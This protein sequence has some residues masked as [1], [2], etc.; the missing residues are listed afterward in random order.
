MSLV[1]LVIITIYFVNHMLLQA[2]WYG[3]VDLEE[4]DEEGNLTY[5]DEYFTV[6]C[7]YY[8][9]MRNPVYCNNISKTEVYAENKKVECV[10][11][12]TGIIGKNLP[13]TT[14]TGGITP[15]CS[16][17]LKPFLTYTLMW[18]LQPQQKP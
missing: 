10:E 14:S 1:L 13:L 8:S 6:W 7:T 18:S 5:S 16:W 3:G 9:V 4:L 15:P 2:V 12:I 17:P 11:G